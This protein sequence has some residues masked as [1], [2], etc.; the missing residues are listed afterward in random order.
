M[1]NSLQ[2][3]IAHARNK[4][5]DLQTIRMLLLSSGWKEKDILQALATETLD[6]P[7]P[8]PT[9]TGSA[10]DAFFHLLTFTTLYATVISL[11]IL[12][13][14]YIGRWFPDAALD[15][16]AYPQ[17]ADV[18]GIRWCIAVVLISFPLFVFL[19]R[20]LHRECQE[21]AE[22]LQSGVRRWLT[23][24]T[25]FITAC[26]LIGD[27]ITTLFTFLNGEL[28]IRFIV[29]A[30]TILF[31]AGLPFSYYFSVLRMDA[32]TYRKSSLHRAMIRVSLVLTTLVVG[33]GISLAGSPMHGRAEKF[34]EQRVNDLRAIQ[35]EIYSEVYGQDRYAPQPAALVSKTLPKP[36]PKDLETVAANAQFQ[37]LRLSDPE[38]LSP[39]QYR[40]SA[41][42]FDLCATFAL[43]RDLSSDIFWNHPAGEHCF[44]FDAM[45]RRVK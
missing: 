31:F 5:M 42:S 33:Y 18:S 41:T 22:K 19:S 4:N 21:H 26:A 39:Y 44:T 35:D 36:L 45:D 9:D 27:G 34:D 14:E 28:S 23:Y 32:D 20:I 29:K 16:Y 43:A 7:V 37:K 3:F 11:I 2:S 15:S 13:F 25:L 12:A 8:V 10:R 1:Q 30:F 38:T 24:I 6:L 40:T 17:N